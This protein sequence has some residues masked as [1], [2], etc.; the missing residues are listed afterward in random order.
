MAKTIFI[1]D[2]ED[3]PFA[4]VPL[5]EAPVVG[6]PIELR[7]SVIH[8]AEVDDERQVVREDTDVVRGVVLEVRDIIYQVEYVS[9]DP[10]RPTSEFVRE[11][12]LAHAEP[13][14]RYG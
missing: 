11:V 14:K 2:G 12:V 10:G 6:A 5:S 9:L 1:W 3:Q 13:E 7:R 8:T 4:T